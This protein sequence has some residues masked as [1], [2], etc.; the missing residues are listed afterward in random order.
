[1]PAP[2]LEFRY[3]DAVT[4]FEATFKT[5]FEFLELAWD[6]S[7]IDFHRRAIGKQINSP[8][9]SQVAQP[10]YTSSVARWQ[11]YEKEF[12]AVAGQ[13]QPYIDAF[14]Y[15]L[16]SKRA[17]VTKSVQY[18]R[19]KDRPD[20]LWFP[21]TT[22]CPERVFSRAANPVVPGSHRPPQPSVAPAC[23]YPDSSLFRAIDLDSSRPNL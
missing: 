4:D 12:E 5:V 13:L 3:E 7:V 2:Y 6:P 16:N 15:G 11:P 14:G 21:A 1:M 19:I 17:V 8:S 23:A 10:L 9:F 22:F 18:C 20:Y